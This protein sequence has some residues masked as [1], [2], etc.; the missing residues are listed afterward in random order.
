[1]DIDLNLHI[2]L[3]W[4]YVPAAVTIVSSI[5]MGIIY[6]SDNRPG[7]GLV[8]LVSVIFW[9]ILNVAVWFLYF[10]VGFFTGIR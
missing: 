5:L 6:I 9:V 8:A 4:F 2:P 3:F 7:Q 1:M 10:A